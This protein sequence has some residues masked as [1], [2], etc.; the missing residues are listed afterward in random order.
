MILLKAFALANTSYNPW[1]YTVILCILWNIPLTNR[2]IM[3]L[4]GYH[5]GIFF[6]SFLREK[7]LFKK[8]SILPVCFAWDFLDFNLSQRKQQASTPLRR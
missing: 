2:G 1:S 7:L 8:K 4:S 5:L 6:L 3:F